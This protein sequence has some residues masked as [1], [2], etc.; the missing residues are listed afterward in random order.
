MVVVM[1]KAVPAV[2]G[3]EVHTVAVMAAAVMVAAAMM[4]V[5]GIAGAVAMAERGIQDESTQGKNYNR[6]PHP[7]SVSHT[8][9]AHARRTQ[10]R[11]PHTY[12]RVEAS[13]QCNQRNYL[14]QPSG[15]RCHHPRSTVRQ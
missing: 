14:C 12:A 8:S 3:T 11:R 4:A 5:A 7:G 15:G 6:N 1:A 9:V 2:V 10:C 13:P